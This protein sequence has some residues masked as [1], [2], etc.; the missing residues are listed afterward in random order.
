M[1]PGRQTPA[2][3]LAGRY[4]GSGPGAPRRC[5]RSGWVTVA[6]VSV[7]R[8]SRVVAAVLFVDTVFYSAITPLVPY[9]VVH[10]HISGATAGL[11]VAGYPAGTFVAALPSGFLAARVGARAALL[12]GITL[13]GIST[14]AFGLTHAVALLILARTVQGAAGACSWAGG[15]AW[16]AVAAPVEQRG[17]LI[18]RAFGAAAAGSLFGPALGGLAT[19]LGPPAAFS[20]AGVLAAA[21]AVIALRLPAPPPEP[22][23]A[24]AELFRARRVPALTRGLALVA[25]AGLAFGVLDVLAPLRLHRLGGSPLLVAAAFLCAAAFET[26]VSPAV[27]RLADRHGRVRP[28]R[29][30]LVGSAV[31]AMLAPTVAPLAVLAV[32]VVIGVPVVGGLYTPSTAL[33][34]DG[35]H[36]AAIPQGV[37]AAALNLVWAV[38]ASLGAAGA[39]RIAGLGS[40]LVPYT[41]LAGCCLLGLPALRGVGSSPP[42]ATTA[43]S[44]PAPAGIEATYSSLSSEPVSGSE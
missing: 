20:V 25:L 42:G 14:V 22:R 13:T 17:R 8:L 19:V 34:A 39:G 24:I 28:L 6:P 11:L 12:F 26:F 37:A 43:G 32:L 29:V 16:L 5:R 23:A 30:C 27:G 31:V 38:G 21:L 2:G 15:L 10:L 18:G 44:A 1:P 40:Q 35:A 7:S 9:D 41:I 4:Q 33:V 36:T 3:K